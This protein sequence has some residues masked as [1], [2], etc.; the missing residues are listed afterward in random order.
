MV[1]IYGP[2]C[3]PKVL[4]NRGTGIIV[5]AQ[6]PLRAEAKTLADALDAYTREYGVRLRAYDG[7]LP[8]VPFE[9]GEPPKYFFYEK[10]DG[11][12]YLV[13][14]H[15]ER[16]SEDIC[17]KQDVRVSLQPGDRVHIGPLAC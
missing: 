2:S 11:D 16:E 1:E 6:D 10:A 15:I 9:D 14:I 3:P 17:P 13:D 8:E 4:P 7:S 5:P 12:W